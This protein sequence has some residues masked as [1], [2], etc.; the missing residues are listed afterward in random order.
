M[1]ANPL[2]LPFILLTSLSDIMPPKAITFG[3]IFD[4]SSKI[5]T[6]KPFLFLDSNIGENVI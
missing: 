2:A 3:W 5:S 6:P 1:L 4:I